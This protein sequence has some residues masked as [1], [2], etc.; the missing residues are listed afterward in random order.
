MRSGV[1]T[2]LFGNILNV[3]RG[4]FFWKPIKLSQT[5]LLEQQGWTGVL[6]DPVPSCCE[7]LRRVRTRSHVFQNA[8]GGPQHRGKL[9]LRVPAG[10]SE[11]THAVA[12]ETAASGS[13]IDAAASVAERRQEAA[14]GD[15]II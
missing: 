10:C 9:R 8:L 4:A 14:D 1:T 7:A 11:L 5:Y 2:C 6:I 3:R 13:E 12:D 15:E